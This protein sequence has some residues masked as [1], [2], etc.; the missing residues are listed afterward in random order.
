MTRIKRRDDRN[1][2]DRK[3]GKRFIGIFL[4]SI[5]LSDFCFLFSDFYFVLSAFFLN[6]YFLL[7]RRAS[8][9]T[10]ENAKNAEAGRTCP[11]ATRFFVFSALQ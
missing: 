2:D 8:N 3:I 11:S 9:S 5:V 7:T 1:I 10:A 6:F 4:S